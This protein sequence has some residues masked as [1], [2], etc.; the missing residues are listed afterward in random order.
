VVFD[1]GES[2]DE[3]WTEEKGAADEAEMGE[4][5]L[6]ALAGHGTDAG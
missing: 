4:L 3:G 2:L 1:D 6:G 5:Q